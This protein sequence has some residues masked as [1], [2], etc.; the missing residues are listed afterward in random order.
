MDTQ[1][2][3]LIELQKLDTEI[4][5]LEKKIKIIP[6]ELDKSM[7]DVKEKEN[8]LNEEKT[9]ISELQKKKRNAEMTLQTKESEI[10]K[11]NT[12]LFE[13]KTNKEYSAMLS[14]IENKKKEKTRL[15][16]SILEIMDEIEKTEIAQKQNEK[17]VLEEKNKLEKEKKVKEEEA[18]QLQKIIDGKKTIRAEITKNISPEVLAK[19]EKLIKSKEGTAVVPIDFKN[20]ACLGCYMGLPPQVI[21]EVRLNNKLINCDK[22]GK[23]LYW[24]SFAE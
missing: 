17:E 11:L 2:S 24:D 20:E 19:Y 18:H 12:Q 13:V 5:Q 8:K 6:E 16:D 22:C 15:E 7:S 4:F 10:D 1:L 9:S 21:N 3:A 23:F 14:E